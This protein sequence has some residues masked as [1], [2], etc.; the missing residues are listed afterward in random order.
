MTDERRYV[1]T[2]GRADPSLHPLRKRTGPSVRLVSCTVHGRPINAARGHIM[3]VSM[4]ELQGYRIEAT[5]GSIGR[6]HELLFD[7]IRWV[8][9]YVV[10]DTGTWLPGRR[11]LISP[12]SVDSID[13]VHK[14][15]LVR[16]DKGRIRNSPDIYTDQPVSRQKEAV[17][18]AYYG[19]GSYWAGP[20]VWGPAVYPRELRRT[21]PYVAWPGTEAGAQAQQGDP[22]LRRTREVAG[23][24]VAATDGEVGHVDD[25]VID[26]EA[27]TISHLV[28]DTSNWPGGRTVLLAPALVRSIEWSRGR[29]HVDATVDRI[30]TGLESRPAELPR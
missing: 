2:I 3:L 30:R 25:F 27:W 22:H 13:G 10:I 18:N 4:R 9:R 29:V 15:V 12:I 26:D 17:F 23:Y 7:D 24:H 8:I 1:A 28:L 5:D 16:L 19:Y 11:V 14:R 20:D 6:V 21:A